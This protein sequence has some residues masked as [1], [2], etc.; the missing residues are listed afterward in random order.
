MH[1][2]SPWAKIS[3]CDRWATIGM[4]SYYSKAV[5]YCLR[6]ATIQGQHLITEIWYFLALATHT[7]THAHARMHTHTH[8]HTYAQ[9]NMQNGYP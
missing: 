9:S 5:S 1:T 3:G 4:R 2:V 8:K 7:H 6:A